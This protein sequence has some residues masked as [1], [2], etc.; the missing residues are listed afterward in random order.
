[1]KRRNADLPAPASADSRP[2]IWTVSVSRLSRLLHDVTPEFD[3]R[4]Q[5]ENIHLG[6]EE[7]VTTLRGRLQRERCDVLIA[8]GSNGAYLKN[9]IDRPVVLVRPDGFDL[10]LALAQAHRVSSRIAVVTHQAE[11]PAFADF[12]DSFG[13]DIPQRAFATAEDAR[14]LVRELVAKGFK[15]IVG[16]GLAADLAEQAG[17]AG[18]LMYSADTIRQAFENAIEMSRQ[19][20]R[21]ADAADAQ[22]LRPRPGRG[23]GGRYTIGDL[24]GDS[25]P[26][27]ALREELRRFAA[28]QRTV[29]ITGDTGT[30]KELV[31]QAIHAGSP[32]RHG[33][34]VAV[35]CGAIAES[36]L[37]S[38]LF[39]YEEG[40]FTGSRRGGHI[41]L[42]ETAQGGTL[43]LD[44]IGEMPLALQTRLLRALEEREVLRVGASRP[45]PIDVRV[46][47]ATHGDLQAM[48]AAGRFRQDL[49]YR[50]NVLRLHLPP[51]RERG[52]DITL[53]ARHFLGTAI[54]GPAP[55]WSEP[56]LRALR[57]HAW[58]G[59]VRELR[60]LVERVAVYA[61]Q[62]DGPVDLALLRR[63]APELFVSSR[64]P[65]VSPAAI[66]QPVAAAPRRRRGI[67]PPRA[68]LQRVLDRAGGDRQLAGQILGVSRTTLWRWLGAAGL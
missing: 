21:A 31:A 28:S 39:G 29:L 52:A 12:Q 8:A 43:F 1:M 41:G 55:E 42:M 68:E 48:T 65:A 14:A 18:I 64:T 49:Y 25:D 15:A 67:P 47:A 33:P 2:V 37:E 9:R 53:L 16:T 58:P 40:A 5:I 62:L 19:M 57:G 3:T 13:L 17:V 24:L 7:A 46:L 45:V 54:R 22:S 44:E 10:M 60:N 38:E 66:T 34:F 32:R 56:A 6:F 30:G 4:A 11:V 35:N 61:E 51:L 23:G 27:A 20:A 63:C 36:L 26:M 50:L 59:N